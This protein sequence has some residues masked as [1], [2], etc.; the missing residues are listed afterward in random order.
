MDELNSLWNKFS[1]EESI[2]RN[3]V[4]ALTSLE[5]RGIVRQFTDETREVYRLN[6]D[7]FR[8]WWYVHHRD[9]KREFSL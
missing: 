5:E 2:R 1:V 7:L 9:L 6:V 4:R 8:R 3:M